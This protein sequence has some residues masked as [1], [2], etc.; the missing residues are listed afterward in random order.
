MDDTIVRAPFSG[1]LGLDDLPVGN[2]IA[3]GQT[4][5]VTISAFDPDLGSLRYH[6]STVFAYGATG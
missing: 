1:I 5:L 2:F 6:G 3:A 4:P